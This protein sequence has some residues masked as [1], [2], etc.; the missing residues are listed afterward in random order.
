[1]PHKKAPKTPFNQNQRMR[2]NNRDGSSSSRT[3][4]FH[5]VQN[6]IPPSSNHTQT[7]PFNGKPLPPDPASPIGLGITIPIPTES[8]STIRLP[9]AEKLTIGVPRPV[10]KKKIKTNNNVPLQEGTMWSSH[11][12]SSSSSSNIPDVKSHITIPKPSSTTDPLNQ[13]PPSRGSSSKHEAEPESTVQSLRQ[14][15]HR[16]ADLYHSGPEG[17]TTKAI[18]EY[19]N[20]HAEWKAKREIKEIVPMRVVSPP[21]PPSPPK[22]QQQQYQAGQWGGDLPARP[23]LPPKEPRGEGQGQ[24]QVRSNING[25]GDVRYDRVRQS[26]SPTAVILPFY[27]S[28]SVRYD[29]GEPADPVSKWTGG[30]IEGNVNKGSDPPIAQQYPP[31]PAGGHSVISSKSNVEENGRR[32]IHTRSSSKDNISRKPNR[33]HHTDAPTT[34]TWLTNPLRSKRSIGKLASK[35]TSTAATLKSKISKPILQSSSSGKW[36]GGSTPNPAAPHPSTAIPSSDKADQEA[37][38]PL[39]P[40]PIHSSHH[41]R[42]PLPA[43]HISQNMKLKSKEMKGTY[44]AG[45]SRIPSQTASFHSSSSFSPTAHISRNPVSS[46]PPPLPP[47]PQEQH[48]WYN[49]T[50]ATDRQPPNKTKRKSR[51]DSDVSFACVG[52]VEER[53]DTRFDVT[54]DESPI[55]PPN[56]DSDDDEWETSGSEGFGGMVPEPLFTASSGTWTVGRGSPGGGDG[57]RVS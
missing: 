24:S 16:A 52:I 53:E 39:P 30:R 33:N 32:Y 4:A 42:P 46:S 6:P 26:D 43:H 35:A 31:P 5:P 14:F 7:T 56:Y 44:S 41:H 23:R 25:A 10:I 21:P 13:H 40:L 38:R 9:E 15:F 55:L 11:P 29:A 28:E 20:F 34:K 17:D 37:M 49:R 19:R 18:R 48:H 47:L 27:A 57:G 50:P 3:D 2:R 45:L 12:S 36:Q 54:A 8:S 22:Q 51:R 1:M